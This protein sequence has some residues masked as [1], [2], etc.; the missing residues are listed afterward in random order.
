MGTM[1][2]TV[3][4]IVLRTRWAQKRSQVETDNLGVTVVPSGPIGGPM[5][6]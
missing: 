6:A 5:N 2:G 1:S 3:I 4:C